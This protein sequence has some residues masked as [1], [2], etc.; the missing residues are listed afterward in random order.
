MASWRLLSALPAATPTSLQNSFYSVLQA[1]FIQFLPVFP[2]QFSLP[3]V[4]TQGV[5][6]PVFV[7]S[8]QGEDIPGAL[9][10][11]ILIWAKSAL[12]YKGTG[13]VKKY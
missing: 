3:S 11:A 9:Q 6:D 8:W 13:I 4:G 1:D 2:I 7:K 10:D 12:G 5:A